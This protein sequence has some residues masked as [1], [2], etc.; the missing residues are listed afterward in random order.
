[1]APVLYRTNSE[2][3]KS[4]DCVFYTTEFQRYL[5]LC[6][7]LRRKRFFG[8]INRG[9]QMETTSSGYSVRES[10]RPAIR[11]LSWLPRPSS[12]KSQDISDRK[13]DQASRLCLRAGSR[14]TVGWNSAERWSVS[15]APSI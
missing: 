10:I 13:S 6:Q 3:D 1:M 5:L 12:I 4:Q 9:N 15:P 7:Q 2:K 14:R 11:I 8:E